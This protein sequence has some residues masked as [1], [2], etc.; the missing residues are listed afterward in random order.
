MKRLSFTLLLVLGTTFINAQIKKIDVAPKKTS[1]VLLKLGEHNFLGNNAAGYINSELY[2]PPLNQERESPDRCGYSY[3]YIEK[4]GMMKAYMPVKCIYYGDYS[5]PD[6]LKDK[7]YT[8][9][10]VI[11]R[12]KLYSSSGE[13]EKYLA[14]IEKEIK[15]TLYFKYNPNM[16]ASFLFISIPFANNANTLYTGKEFV[17]RGAN[18]LNSDDDIY[19]V[20]TGNPVN[21]SPGMVWVCKEVSVV[22]SSL[23]LILE[24]SKGET[25][26]YPVD[27]IDSDFLLDKKVS[28]GYKKKYGVTKWNKM[29]RR[30]M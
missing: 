12:D 7:Y 11:E 23:S 24:N 21:Y 30:L 28:D 29:L 15:D 2:L 25:V 20:V 14:I 5:D 10:D 18:W 4:N 1:E 22:K 16:E 8:V 13:K 6:Y 27:M 26:Y 17:S 3:F 9:I 19:D